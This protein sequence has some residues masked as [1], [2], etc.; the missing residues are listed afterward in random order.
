MLKF[1][2]HILPWLITAGALY[3]AFRDIEWSEFLSRLKSADRPLLMLATF[4][5]VCSYLLR[6]RRWE[7]LFPEFVLSYADS[8]KVLFLGFFMNNTLPARAGELVRAHA[9]ARITGCRRTLVLATVFNE[10]L[11]DGLTISA[12]FAIFS[13]GIGDGQMSQD[14]SL[15]AVAFGILTAV[16]LLALAFRKY[17]SAFLSSLTSKSASRASQYAL[18]RAGLFLDGLSPLF[19]PQRLPFLVLSSLAV[20]LVEISVYVVIADAYGAHL[21]LP[22][23]VLFLVSVNFSSLIPAAPG[24]IGVIEAVTLVV[25]TSLGIDREHALAMVMTQH[26]IQYIVVGIPGAVAMISLKN[27]IAGFRHPGPQED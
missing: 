8:V 6:A 21:T 11:A 18:S 26:I 19:N 14:F 9:G 24:G 17:I 5:T 4:I 1:L 27:H 10:R 2:K 3:F 15:V 7:Y 20:W 13:L 12:L 23:S 22:Q 16:V 25:L